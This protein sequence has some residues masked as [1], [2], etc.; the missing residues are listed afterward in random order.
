MN[1]ARRNPYRARPECTWTSRGGAIGSDSSDVPPDGT[2][3]QASQQ[4][5][6]IQACAPGTCHGKPAY[7]EGHL[8]APTHGETATRRHHGFDTCH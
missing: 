7:P 6:T 3:S 2:T 1:S 5:A 8:V 4:P